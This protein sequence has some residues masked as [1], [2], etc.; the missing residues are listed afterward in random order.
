MK[1]GILGSGSWGTA[2]AKILTDNANTIWWWNRS[3][4]AIEQFKI[5]KH[6][7]QYPTAARFDTNKL[8]LT[9][10]VQPLRCYHHGYSFCI[11]LRCIVNFRCNHF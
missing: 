10:D 7:P 2:I 9:T 4:D 8:Q 6:N 1:F 3:A 11:Y 5:R